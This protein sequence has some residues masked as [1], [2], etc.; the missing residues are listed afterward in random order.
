DRTLRSCAPFERAAERVDELPAVAA[1]NEVRPV[2]VRAARKCPDVG[3]AEHGEPA[4]AVAGLDHAAAS[5]PVTIQSTDTSSAAASLA[6]D[7]ALGFVLPV[8]QR[9]ICMTS[10]SRR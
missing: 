7:S 2:R 4:E 10:T 6:S 3:H 8:S 1:G 5:A 9:E